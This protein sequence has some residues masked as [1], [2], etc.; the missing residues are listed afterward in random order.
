[1]KGVKGN[2]F[3]LMRFA[4]FFLEGKGY[5]VSTEQTCKVGNLSFRVDVVGIRNDKLIAVECGNIHKLIGEE[6]GRGRIPEKLQL[7]SEI[8]DK[9]IWIPYTRERKD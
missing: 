9:V 2:H 7:L 5:K 4:C 6:K 3:E 1:M 8:F